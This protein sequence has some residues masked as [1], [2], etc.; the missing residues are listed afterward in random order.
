MRV[1]GFITGKDGKI[2]ELENTLKEEQIFVGGCIE[3]KFYR[4]VRLDMQ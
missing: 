2:T 3:I 4:G 1:F